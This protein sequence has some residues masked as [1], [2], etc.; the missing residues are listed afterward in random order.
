MAT[1]QATKSKYQTRE[2]DKV[3]S[4][5]ERAAVAAAVLRSRIRIALPNGSRRPMSVP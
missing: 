4:E 3:F 5:A 2:D 1:K